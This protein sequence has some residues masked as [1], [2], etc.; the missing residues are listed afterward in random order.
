MPCAVFASD[1]MVFLQNPM[2]HYYNFPTG[3]CQ[4]FYATSSPTIDTT[5]RIASADFMAHAAELLAL[6]FDLLQSPFPF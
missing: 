3:T 6:Q 4:K 2:G 1:G 5:N